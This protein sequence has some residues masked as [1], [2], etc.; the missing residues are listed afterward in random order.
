MIGQKA[1]LLPVAA[2]L[3]NNQIDPVGYICLFSRAENGESVRENTSI[4]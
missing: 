3:K 2:R 1:S 4:G